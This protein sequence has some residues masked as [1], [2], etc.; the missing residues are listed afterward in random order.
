MTNQIEIAPPWE[1]KVR[2]FLE[3]EGIPLETVPPGQGAPVRIDQAPPKRECLP[4]RLFPKGRIPCALAL[5]TARRLGISPGQMGKLLDFL[6]IKVRQ[7]QLG[8]F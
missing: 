6:E 1:P 5:E 8:C 7:C 3:K 4:G 2:S